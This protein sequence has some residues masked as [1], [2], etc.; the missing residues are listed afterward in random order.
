[1]RTALSVPTMRRGSFMSIGAVLQAVKKRTSAASERFTRFLLVVPGETSEPS[2]ILLEAAA[3]AG[4]ARAAL[5]GVDRRG[6]GVA[7]DPSDRQR[8]EEDRVA[9]LHP[10]VE[11]IVRQAR[12]RLRRNERRERR[13]LAQDRHLHLHVARRTVA[14][15]AQRGGGQHRNRGGA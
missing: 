1:M 15:R 13:E 11:Q 7:L 14:R 12:A 4:T 2:A 10:A 8:V 3:A 9:V 6:R 5:R